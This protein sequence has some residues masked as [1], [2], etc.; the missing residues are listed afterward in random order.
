M[1]DDTAARQRELLT[2]LLLAKYEPIAIVGAG[3]RFPGGNEDLPGF[4]EFLRN[5]RSG[6]GPVPADRWDVEAYYSAEADAKGKVRTLG[7]GFL[8]GI[9]RFDAKFF[10]ISP[11]EANCI[12]PQQRL[13]LEACWH[14]L[15]QANLDPDQLRGG[16]GGVY[17]GVSA[18]DYLM[19]L[20]ALPDE[21][22]EG[23]LGTGGAHSAVAGRVS[24][25][26]G[27]HGPCI[28]LDTACSSSLVALHVAVQGL[29]GGECDIALCGGVA[30]VHHP[31][32]H[33]I[34]SD[35][36]MLSPDG[37]CKTF[38]DSA[39]GYGRSEG[40]GVL[41]LKRLSDAKRDGDNVLAL[42]RGTAIGQDGASGGLT[43]PNG[44]A[45]VALM[46]SALAAARL[47]PGDIQYVE[48]HGTG[49][50]LG[51][52]IELGA[53]HDVFAESHGP[54]TSLGDP[55]VVGS[56]KTNVGHMEPAAGVGGVVKTVLQL[57]EGVVYPH[58]N[59][60]TPSRYI[61]WD[62]WHVTVPTECRPWAGAPRRA[63]VNSFGFQGTLA[64]VVLEQAPPLPMPEADGSVDPGIF[65]LS[66]KG[67][68]SLRDQV[69]RYREVVDGFQGDVR[70]L[71]YT[72]NVGRAHFSARVAG[73][74]RDRDE[75]LRLLDRQAA[76]LEDDAAAGDFRGQDV[77]FLFTGQGSQYAGMGRALYDRFPVFREHVDECDEL[78]APRLGRSIRSIM[79]DGRDGAADLDQT[80]YTQPALFTLEY[81]LARLWMSWGIRPSVLIGHS[82]GEIAAAAVA[83]L[84]DLP[85]AVTLVAARARLMQSV[86]TPGGMAAV[87]APA[88]D[89]APLLGG[90]DD[91]AFAAMNAPRQCVISGGVG[92]LATVTER[93]RDRGVQ[94]Q[95]LVVSHAFHSPLMAEVFDA[96][97]EAIAGLRF[98]EP[99]L[100]LI[101]N[102]TGRVAT[103]AELS[104]PDYWVR[105]IGEPVDFAAGMGCLERRGRHA[106]VEVGP[107]AALTN[108]GRRCVAA[109]GDQLWLTSLHRRDEDGT[110]ILESLAKLYAA[111]VPVSWAAFHADRPSRRR[112]DLP[113]YP[114][115]RKRY[116]LPLGRARSAGTRQLAVAQEHPLLG[117]EVSTPE[118][119]RAGVREFA[120]ELS[121][122]HPA[123]LADHV[124]MG[125]VVFP[126]AGYLEIVLALQDALYGETR[127]PIENVR[128]HEPLFLTAER[129]T[130]V[131][132]RVE[133]RAFGAS[134]E[135]VSRVPGASNGAANG[136][137]ERLHATAVVGR[138][139]HR[140][141]EGVTA[142]PLP[143]NDLV[144]RVELAGEPELVR[145]SGDFYAQLAGM[146]L[147]YGPHFQ[148]LRTV[149]RH[150]AELA[151]GELAE[152]HAAAVE[153]LPPP[154]LDGAMQALVA[155]GSGGQTYLPVR[156]GR[157][158][159]VKKPKGELRSLVRLRAPEGPSDVDLVADVVL[160]EDG[161][162]V[163]VLSELGL[164]RVA[165]PARRSRQPLF[166][167]PRWLKR[168]LPAV[169]TATQPRHVLVM[170]RSEA[171][172]AHLADR[173][174]QANVRLTFASDASEVDIR[175]LVDD[176]T[177]T[178]VCWFWTPQPG[179]DVS[180]EC[181]RNLWDLCE[182]TRIL[183][184]ATF[185]PRVWLVT[186]GAQWLPGDA[187]DGRAVEDLAAATLWGF[188][189]T[190]V[191]EYPR[192]RV[193]LVDL[194]AGADDH[195]CLLD[196]W[197]AA[198]AGELQIAYRA[199]GPHLRPLRHVKRLRPSTP[200]DGANYELAITE[201]GQFSN[202]RPVPV[203]D[204]APAGDEIQVRM[205]AVGLNFKDVVNAL[206]LLKQHAED[207]GVP[208]RPMPLGIEGA[209]TVIAAG[210]DAE[211][212]V[213]DEVLVGQPGC[214][215]RRVTVPS[216]MAV[217][218]PPEIGFAE[219]AG[220]VSTYGTA[221][222][223]L[224]RLAGIKAGD[225]VLIHAAAGGVGQAA[226][227]LAMLAGAEVYAT[228]SP[229]KWPLLRA[230]GVRHVMNSRTLDFADEVLRATDGRGVD[231]V[232][233][234]LNKDH[235]AAGLRCL[236]EGGRFVELG[237]IGVLTPAQAHELRPDVSYH[238]FDL[239]ELDEDALRANRTDLRSILDLVARGDL[240]PPTTTGYRP[241][242]VAEALGVL[243]RGAN[244]G[245]LVVSLVD[246]QAPA[247]SGA[248]LVE[249]T[250]DRTYLITGGLG[251]LGMIAARKLVELGARHL[252]LMTRRA[253]SAEEA[254]A[255]AG[256]LAAEPGD[257]VT[258]TVH[259]GDVG[260]AEDVDRLMAA[261]RAGA[262]PLGGIVHA[263]GVL[264]DAPAAAQTW[265]RLDTVFRPKV[266]GSLLLHRALQA[267]ALQAGALD[268]GALAG[269]AF[270]DVRF[271]VGYS[272]VASILGNTGQANYAAANAFLDTL[273]QWRAA[274]GLPGLSVNWGPWAGA[275]MAAELDERLAQGIAAQ[276]ISFLEP[277]DA[278]RALVEVMGRPVAQSM[279]CEVDWKRYTAARLADNAL[280]E[281]VAQG[282][283][284]ERDL[285]ID[286]DALRGKPI[287]EREE[288]INGYLRA[289]AGEVLRFDSADDIDPDAK[290]AELGVDSLMA[291]ELKNSL[292]AAFGIPLPTSA[293]F[294][295]PSVP[296]LA[297]FIGEQLGAEPAEESPIE[298]MEVHDLTDA[299]AEAELAAM[300]ALR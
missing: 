288:I 37:K 92:S 151:A 10:N 5:G 178:D 71:C 188:G 252:E 82:I 201:Y 24:Y 261:L 198:G 88:A 90:F 96:F 176:P 116:W 119:L 68:R 193:T 200:D 35:A 219:A 259:Q 276:G 138:A 233:N 115:E 181:E 283:G 205:H 95:Q 204:V 159:L 18:V 61:P 23:H 85:D 86:S 14:A 248:R 206:G 172:F 117:G 127:R 146:G 189:A 155:A 42:V 72:G 218:K 297:R 207:T 136:S 83:G 253:V 228:A 244:V 196:E 103:F 7:G 169:D 66:A 160:L 109:A 286:L 57:R 54:G 94:V 272:S 122:T 213:G 28:A 89:V 41:V 153:H 157:L 64:S 39:D 221:H 152:Y 17:L 223:A 9:D 264:A 43:V 106:F 239:N 190:L 56:L 108:L 131:R 154:V 245:K 273:M 47:T 132:T 299:E 278:M 75:L 148:R 290:F 45:Q 20:E 277:D 100:T 291:V 144:E 210:P 105:H 49:T 284:G 274:H 134:V 285:G 1:T 242:E 40:C 25:F 296:L 2:E 29:R 231:I 38:D 186:A 298:L 6:T 241:D 270:P 246:D 13:V 191:N 101:S 282:G 265:T 125:H 287:A 209:G 167:E 99:E 48:A 135:V 3:L 177:V 158:Q 212:G 184:Q 50:S 262:H 111:G 19:E 52:P 120:T 58:I 271:F 4:A 222:Y 81:A 46:R 224:H 294:D 232:L 26:L 78:F 166:H 27:W 67:R 32:N 199:G 53:I 208:H 168:S 216:A 174:A 87:A 289:R 170:R 266:Y 84:F 137:I 129:P 156:F 121:A 194:P 293:V 182:F 55:I 183:D 133:R 124:V 214:A 114:F 77:A 255:L 238:C 33:V 139:A 267:G 187:A 235:I 197:L 102:L 16:S 12:D 211:F 236:A 249:V 69:R 104:T 76:K 22:L 225:R 140:P 11:K 21:E 247:S 195:E 281:L 107:S 150:G 73:V 141:V 34:L 292:E 192:Y 173:L 51:D 163:C 8:D 171:D 162:A 63:M 217:R 269:G 80:L 74:V 128:I 164:K 98:H 142:S 65:T 149:A 234:S 179:A 185:S 263:A 15:E 202:V 118:Q 220:L 36:G 147:S 175:G 260:S 126:G 268:D 79:F 180:A 237:K 300:K 123:Y 31:L 143:E 250:P 59:L 60:R 130:E 254:A 257:G 113:L 97:R 258:V 93:L 279:I 256:Q 44:T 229:W 62:S 161:R 91:L 243:S 251:A 230:K 165:D 295:Y 110:T 203:E 280:L 240:A 70:D 227:Q 226:V 215:M 275:G 30:A 145:H 112:V